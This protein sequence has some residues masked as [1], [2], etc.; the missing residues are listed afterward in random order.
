[1]ANDTTFPP[2]RT[3]TSDPEETRRLGVETGRRVNAGVIVLEGALGAGK[4][5]FV[6]GMAEGLGFR[7]AGREAGSP[8]FVLAREYPGRLT[9]VHID[10]YRLDTIGPETG[11]WLTETFE[12]DAVVA[13]E[14]GERAAEWL[15]RDH[16]R[17]RFEHGAGGSRIIECEVHGSVDFR[18]AADKRS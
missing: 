1:M 11:D 15:P 12:R 2:R 17:I 4:T 6:K 3:I 14:W 13:L 5:T 7:S 9:L 18:P 10:L 16:L 8:T